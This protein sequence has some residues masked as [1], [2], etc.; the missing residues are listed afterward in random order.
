MSDKTYKTYKYLYYKYKHKYALL[1]NEIY[2]QY[3]G[4]PPPTYVNVGPTGNDAQGYAIMGPS[5]TAGTTIVSGSDKKI[6]NVPPV[7][8]ASPGR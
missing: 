3:G 5:P 8:R 1:K 4:T 6:V 7:L 2:A